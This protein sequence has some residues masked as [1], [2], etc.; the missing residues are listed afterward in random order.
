MKTLKTIGEYALVFVAVSLG[1]LV[2]YI[3]FLGLHVFIKTLQ[4]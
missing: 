1:V 4:S 3:F 2:F